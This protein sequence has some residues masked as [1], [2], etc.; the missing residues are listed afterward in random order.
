MNWQRVWAPVQNNVT[1][2]S[3]NKQSWV[4]QTHLRFHI[5]SMGFIQRVCFQQLVYFMRILYCSQLCVWTRSVLTQLVGTNRVDLKPRHCHTVVTH[6]WNQTWKR[7]SDT[8]LS[9][10]TNTACKK[11]K[12]YSSFSLINVK[13]LWKIPH[14][15]FTKTKIAI[16]RWQLWT[17][18]PLKTQTL[19]KNPKQNM[20]SS[21]LRS[22]NQQM[23]LLA[24]WLKQFMDY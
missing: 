9:K 19:K 7:H 16:F 22:K 12:I 5:I 6:G 15:T 20:Q 10:T 8:F 18:S 14:N 11:E 4:A 2:S 24:P 3:F 17:K 23:F 13:E 1:Q 21:H